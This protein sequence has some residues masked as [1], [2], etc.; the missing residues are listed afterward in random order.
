MQLFSTA[1]LTGYRR[2]YLSI[3]YYTVRRPCIRCTSTRN[4]LRS[5]ARRN[6]GRF[7]I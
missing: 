2:L 6:Y 7:Q 4:P 5:A 3:I 1:L